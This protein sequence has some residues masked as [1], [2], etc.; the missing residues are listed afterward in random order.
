M[1]YGEKRSGAFPKGTKYDIR[2]GVR[3]L[4]K[5]DMC[6]Y[7]EGQFNV[8][9]W[10]RVVDEMKGLA[11]ER[12]RSDAMF[13]QAFIVGG[14]KYLKD[15]KR[16][17][18]DIAFV[19]PGLRHQDFDRR[20]TMLG[21][22]M[23]F[24]LKGFDAD[25]A[26]VFIRY[27]KYPYQENIVELKDGTRLNVDIHL[28]ESLSEQVKR[29][30]AICYERVNLF[31][32]A[33]PWQYERKIK[34]L[35]QL[36]YYLETEARYEKILSDYRTMEICDFLKVWDDDAWRYAAALKNWDETGVIPEGWESLILGKNL[37][38]SVDNGVRNN[39]SSPSKT[40]NPTKQVQ[41][42]L[43]D[44][45]MYEAAI[46]PGSQGMP[47]NQPPIIDL[48]GNEK[49]FYTSTAVFNA[50]E[51][52]QDMF[53]FLQHQKINDI[54]VIGPAAHEIENLLKR[55]NNARITAIDIDIEQLD[56]ARHRKIRNQGEPLEKGRSASSAVNV[57]GCALGSVGKEKPA[58][59]LAERLRAITERKGLSNRKLA[60]LSG[61]S[62]RT[63]DELISG[64]RNSASQKIID[65]LHP[66]L[67]IK[68]N[69]LGFK[70]V[71]RGGL[72]GMADAMRDEDLQRPRRVQAA[73]V[74][75]LRARKP[76]ESL[77]AKKISDILGEQNNPATAK[78]VTSFIA[79]N[80]RLCAMFSGRANE[81]THSFMQA[82]KR[83]D[84]AVDFFNQGLF[85]AAR[86]ECNAAIYI[87][88]AGV[89]LSN[90]QEKLRKKAQ[91]L[92]RQIMHELKIYLQNP[93][94]KI[95]DTMDK[96]V[97][98]LDQRIAVISNNWVASGRR[99]LTQEDYS[100]I[101]Q[102][103]HGYSEELLAIICGKLS[104]IKRLELNR[105][106]KQ[107]EE[108]MAGKIDAFLLKVA[109]RIPEM[110][111]QIRRQAKSAP[112][113]AAQKPSASSSSQSFP[114]VD[115]GYKFYFF[116]TGAN[117][118]IAEYLK[119]NKIREPTFEEKKY[120][121][122]AL[123][124]ALNYLNKKRAINARINAPPVKVINTE[125]I[126]FGACFD[127]RTIYVE[128]PV[129]IDR[130]LYDLAAMFVYLFS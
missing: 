41:T 35:V 68:L 28:S 26:Q 42:L 86:F 64:R 17:D 109:S 4:E 90:N 5:S 121:T 69:E 124:A 1:R 130:Q 122:T 118:N 101:E 36:F 38:E 50:D 31:G 44:S 98:L 32:Y 93:F 24:V 129:I 83:L 128:L 96:L 14:V 105:G 65:K 73:I 100:K 117:A 70:L 95:P 85:D 63:I 37:G 127:T 61:V 53:E 107:I 34:T 72:V 123:R 76:G 51:L 126:T 111:A 46:S 110:A 119:Y 25:I 108:A 103:L 88:G 6:V 23:G 84:R 49:V 55:F 10:S 33:L 9:L 99:A 45:G 40:S 62:R 89:G 16:R 66:F 113:V 120:I 43:L 106:I 58:L 80:P 75:I 22:L 3:S 21:N 20:L 48:T 59:T 12:L 39:T 67:G 27:Q 60:E 47:G 19:W 102:S 56:K 125:K 13:L 104:S 74:R 87:I 81:T 29:F 15:S 57:R 82:H 91:E 52:L 18:I 114:G 54:L 92:I 79:D 116:N 78:E 112:S 94:K 2:N 97:R 8:Q 115:K 71:K 30:L 11:R 7:R 77:D